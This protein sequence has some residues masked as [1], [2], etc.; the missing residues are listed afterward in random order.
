MLF[1]VMYFAKF[2]IEK[3]CIKILAS[4]EQ[5]KYLVTLSPHSYVV[6]MLGAN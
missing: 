3:Y 4:L 2:K 5:Q 6:A 1:N